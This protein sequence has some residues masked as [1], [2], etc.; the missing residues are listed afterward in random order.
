MVKVTVIFDGAGDGP[1]GSGSHILENRIAG[2]KLLV[3]RSEASVSIFLPSPNNPEIL[4]IHL[5]IYLLKAL[6][7]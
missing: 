5:F 2:G 3:R 4:F 6:E 1:G 7:M